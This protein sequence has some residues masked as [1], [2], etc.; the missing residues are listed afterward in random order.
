[1]LL[2]IIENQ[3]FIV[4]GFFNLDFRKKAQTPT[5]EITRASYRLEITHVKVNNSLSR[6]ELMGKQNLLFFV[7]NDDSK[8][9]REVTKLIRLYMNRFVVEEDT[10]MEV[11]GV[12]HVAESDL[13]IIHRDEKET[14][15]QSFENKI[16]DNQKIDNILKSVENNFISKVSSCETHCIIGTLFPASEYMSEEYTHK[17]KKLILNWFGNNPKSELLNSFLLTLLMG[18]NNYSEETHIED[19]SEY[20]SDYFIIQQHL[21]SNTFHGKR[22]Q[23]ARKYGKDRAKTVTED[24]EKFL[25]QIVSSITPL[26]IWPEATEAMEGKWVTSRS[27]S[28][29]STKILHREI[30]LT[31]IWNRWTLSMN[32]E[33]DMNCDIKHVTVH[34]KCCLL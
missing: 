23:L 31:T 33:H 14:E 3:N 11:H 16:Y 10:Q 6:K 21:K 20:G 26:R 17:I 22:I 7:A 9:D 18:Q 29:I 19:I 24:L 8:A 12:Y 15:N 1:M 30:N 13:Q 2:P 34:R 28:Q 32:I 25:H 4:L 27:P 5:F